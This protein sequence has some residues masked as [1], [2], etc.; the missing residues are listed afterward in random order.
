MKREFHF[1]SS[2][3]LEL[4]RS[5][6]SMSSF[7]FFGSNCVI[8]LFTLSLTFLLYKKN[9]NQSAAIS[10]TISECY[11]FYKNEKKRRMVFR[12]EVKLIITAVRTTMTVG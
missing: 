1:S 8:V 4:Y 7:L 9:D 3:L 6:S 5:L 11:I 10:M 12:M 2:I